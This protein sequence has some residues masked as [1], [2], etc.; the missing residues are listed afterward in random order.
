MKPLAYASI[1]AMVA[2][3][4]RSVPSVTVTVP[5]GQGP[6]HDAPGP[7]LGRP[8]EAPVEAPDEFRAPL[9]AASDDHE[10]FS[11]QLAGIEV[12]EDPMARSM[13]AARGDQETPPGET[14]A[15]LIPYR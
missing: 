1:I 6:P 7:E 9:A 10:A 12:Q 5:F 3:G 11:L 2:I 14:W 4:I 15:V 8:L 13:S